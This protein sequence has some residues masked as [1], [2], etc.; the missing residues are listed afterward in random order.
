MHRLEN[1]GRLAAIGILAGCALT[2]AT[3]T[4][5]AGTPP[6]LT[7]VEALG[8]ALFFDTNL[9]TPAGQSCASCHEPA[10]GFTGPSSFINAHGAV[11]E[12]AVAGLFGKRKPP[13]AAYATYSPD[14]GFDRRRRLFVGGQFWDGRA[15]NTAEQAKEP[16]LNPV[17]MAMP[18]EAWRMVTCTSVHRP[19]PM[20]PGP[21]ARPPSA[22]PGS[23]T[24]PAA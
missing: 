10:A 11:M 19:G 1:T 3:R 23:S 9:S 20:A 24:R 22:A 7:P 2:L 6:K 8:K 17:E 13:S 5:A 18:D 14:F 16:F 15:A 4:V 12:G 21:T